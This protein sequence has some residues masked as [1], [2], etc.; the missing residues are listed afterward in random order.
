LRYFGDIFDDFDRAQKNHWTRVS[1]FSRTSRKSLKA[2]E[3]W[4]FDIL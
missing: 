3:N 4:I 1:G 2:L